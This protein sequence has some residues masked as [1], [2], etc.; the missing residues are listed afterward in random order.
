MLLKKK[1]VELRVTLEE[2]QA[3]E[4]AA[5][6]SNTTLSRFIA[7]SAKETAQTVINEHKRLMITHEQWDSVMH[8]LHNPSQPTELMKEILSS[9]TEETWTVQVNR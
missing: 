9:S 5:T 2:K 4:E 8:A 7:E 3:L 1:R 6:L